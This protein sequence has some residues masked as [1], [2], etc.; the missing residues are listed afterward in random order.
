MNYWGPLIEGHIGLPNYVDKTLLTI[1]PM[2]AKYMKQTRLYHPCHQNEDNASN[3]LNMGPELWILQVYSVWH[4]SKL[5]LWGLWLPGSTW[6]THEETKNKWGSRRQCSTNFEKVKS[7]WKLQLKTCPCKLLTKWILVSG[8]PLTKLGTKVLY[9]FIG[10]LVF[11]QFVPNFYFP[12]FYWHS[13]FCNSLITCTSEGSPWTMLLEEG[14][15]RPM[16]L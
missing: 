1:S 3:H 5:P 6:E 4:W 8:N 11:A 2:K 13:W 9:T 10:V 15:V 12:R 16:N 14:K 7:L